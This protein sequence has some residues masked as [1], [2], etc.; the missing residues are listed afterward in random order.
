MYYVD[1]YLPF[2]NKGGGGKTWAL[3]EGGGGKTWLFMKNIHP[4]VYVYS[5]VEISGVQKKNWSEKILG[6]WFWPNF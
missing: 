2:H 1:K 4:C 5:I 3:G 6:I